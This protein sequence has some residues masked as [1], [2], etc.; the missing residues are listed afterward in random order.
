[1]TKAFLVGYGRMGK[2][3]EVL[4]KDYGLEII[5]H[6]S[7]GIDFINQADYQASDVVIEFTR[8]DAALDNLSA[9]LISGKPV[10]SGTTGWLED[11]SKIEDIRAQKGGRFFYASNFSFGANVTFFLNEKLAQLMATDPS[12]SV[13]I[14]E[15]H[16]T[17][18]KDKP[19]G[20]AATLAEAIISRNDRYQSWKVDV[21]DASDD[22]LIACGREPDIRG[23]HQVH[24]KNEI[25]EIMLTHNA[26]SRDGFAIGAIRAAIWLCQQKPGKYGMKDLMGLE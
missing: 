2:K 11:W 7:S 14:K 25:D 24:Y 23:Y 1:M 26:F 8:P 12:Y 18:K 16:H 13:S 19:S 6:V 10:V 4:A 20:T 21:A 3:I 17:G 15:V 22:L 5:G 9:I